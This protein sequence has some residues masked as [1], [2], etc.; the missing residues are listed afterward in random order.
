MANCNKPAESTV[1]PNAYKAQPTIKVI[2]QMKR[3]AHH[4]KAKAALAPKE[5]V[6]I[7]IQYNRNYAKQS[8]N[9]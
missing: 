6:E 9:Q 4:R 7:S 3:Y 1:K 8:G 5:D 2:K